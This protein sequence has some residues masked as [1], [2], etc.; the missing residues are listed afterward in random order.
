VYG[1]FQK[2]PNVSIAVWV[3]EFADNYLS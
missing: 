1:L 3:L 2:D